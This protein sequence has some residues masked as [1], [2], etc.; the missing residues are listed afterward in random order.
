MWASS[1][2]GYFAALGRFVL[3]LF[4]LVVSCAMRVA[5]QDSNSRPVPRYE[6]FGGYMAAGQAGGYSDLQFGNGIALQSSFSS[7]HGV[8]AS[9]LH[10][11]NRILGVKADFSLQPHTEDFHVGI[12]TQLPCTPVILNTGINPKL[13]NFLTGP[14]IKLRNHTRF[15][16]YIHGLAGIAHAS[17][18]FTISGTA[19]NL[20]LNSSE[21]GFAAAVGGGSDIR[22]SNRFSFRTGMDFNPAWVGRDDT[23]ARTVLKNVRLWG[24]LLFH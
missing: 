22:F 12:C 5:A 11:F 1:S 17:A 15:T 10:N 9:F 4:I 8:E 7:T 20:S 2:V 19:V 16:P 21:T 23:G 13:L 6:V 24:G 18:S 14:E 3:V